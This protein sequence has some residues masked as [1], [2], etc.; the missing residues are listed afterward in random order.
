[1]LSKIVV[2]KQSL[3]LKLHTR[4]LKFSSTV[5]DL[6]RS[7]LK[8]KIDKNVYHIRVHEFA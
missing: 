5:P 3:C 1:M 2:V 6:W 7:A 4:G 8:K